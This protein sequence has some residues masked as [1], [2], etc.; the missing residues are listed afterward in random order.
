MS[1][2]KFLQ[3]A[4]VAAGAAGIAGFAAWKFSLH[5]LEVV[6]V[7]LPIARLPTALEGARLV[8]LSD[9]HV[10]PDV[11]DAYMLRAFA[12]AESLRPDILAFT[13]DFVS[14]RGPQQL[15]QLERAMQAVPSASLARIAILGNHDYGH[16]WREPQVAESIVKT[17]S[18]HGVTFIRNGV[19]VVEGLSIVGIDDWW[20]RQS[21]VKRARELVAKDAP[22]LVLCHNPDVADHA[23]WE[24][25]RGWML[26]GHTHGGQCKPPF[27][28][29]PLL[30][31]RNKRYAAGPVQTGDGR[32]VYINRGIGHTLP[33]RVN[34]RPEITSYRLARA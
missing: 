24:G 8:Q 22:Q 12:L 27:M 33:I 4:G 13:G 20:A 18:N 3:R 31:V 29:P 25:Y 30:P 21:D 34:V 5:H 16:N 15:A 1:R 28:A 14:W 6:D 7:A 19:Q 32:T 10:G 23:V 17:V 9:L 11:D 2:R 26:S